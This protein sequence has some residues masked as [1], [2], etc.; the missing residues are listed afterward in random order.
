M[1]KSKHFSSL[2]CIVKLYCSIL[3]V[4]SLVIKLIISFIFC[5]IIVSSI[6]MKKI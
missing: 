4:G 5:S 3:I 6:L 2:N 1:I